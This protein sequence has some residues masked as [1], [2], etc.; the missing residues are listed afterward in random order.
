MEYTRDI[1]PLIVH[2]LQQTAT[3][4]KS[5]T[6]LLSLW[7]SAVEVEEWRTTRASGRCET[8]LQ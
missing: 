6:Q 1:D 8:A 5:A 7:Q 4:G 2:Q 3:H